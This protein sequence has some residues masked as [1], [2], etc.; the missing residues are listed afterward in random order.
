MPQN[1]IFESFAVWASSQRDKESW[2]V[3]LQT[4]C[5]SLSSSNSPQV[6]DPEV[7]VFACEAEY[8]L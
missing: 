4:P 2:G 7:L 1:N 8:D 3:Q 6:G 5:S